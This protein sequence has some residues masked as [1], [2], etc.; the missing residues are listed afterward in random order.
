MYSIGRFLQFAALVLLP[1]GLVVGMV[2]KDLR[3]EM[4]LLAASL[5][6]FTAGKMLQKR[7]T[8]DAE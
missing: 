5:V 8:P 4:T 1:T 2:E 6:I 7:S 3:F